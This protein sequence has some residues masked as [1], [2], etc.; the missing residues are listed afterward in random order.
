VDGYSAGPKQS[1]DHPLGVGGT[2]LM[3]WFFPTRT[4]RRMHNQE[5]PGTA[6]LQTVP[7]RLFGEQDGRPLRLAH[8]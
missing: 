2:G 8:P 4:F 6:G 1:L 5:S 7:K 3:E